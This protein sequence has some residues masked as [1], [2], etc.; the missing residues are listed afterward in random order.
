MAAMYCMQMAREILT[1][2]LRALIAVLEGQTDDRNTV[3]PA[4]T[5]EDV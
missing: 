4:N 1:R 3:D 5:R 2:R